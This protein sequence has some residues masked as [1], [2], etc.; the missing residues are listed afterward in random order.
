MTEAVE[1]DALVSLVLGKE[2]VRETSCMSVETARMDSSQ[3]FQ[4]NS[5]SQV[6][7]ASYV[8]V[9]ILSRL[10]MVLTSETLVLCKDGV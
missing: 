5:S 7:S 2:G 1:D 10:R 6:N 4:L 8:H 3:G 9:F